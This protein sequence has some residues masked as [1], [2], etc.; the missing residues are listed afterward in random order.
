MLDSLK[1][2]IKNGLEEAARVIKT[3]LKAKAIAAA[4]DGS[5]VAAIQDG[6]A[7]VEAAQAVPQGEGGG[8]SAGEDGA[9]PAAADQDGI[10]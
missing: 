1:D 7:L 2:Y 6:A 10:F 5:A 9:A 4:K 3:E 8:D